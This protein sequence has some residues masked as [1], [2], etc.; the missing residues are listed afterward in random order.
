[1][2]GAGGTTRGSSAR[3]RPA[4]PSLQHGTPPSPHA[5]VTYDENGHFCGLAPLC[6]MTQLLSLRVCARHRAL[7]PHPFHSFPFPFHY[8]NYYY[9]HKHTYTRAAQQR[10]C[11]ERTLP[12]APPS[13]V[14]TSLSHT[15]AQ[16]SRPSSGSGC[17]GATK[18]SGSLTHLQGREHEQDVRE[19]EGGRG[20]MGPGGRAAAPL[21]VRAAT[22][23]AP[24]GTK[25]AP[26][27]HHQITHPHAR[28]PARTGVLART[29]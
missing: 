17:H 20:A 8:L 9:F 14:S 18:S 23:V 21:G 10:A 19:G 25:R 12:S 27:S 3:R 11:Q 1:M 15:S 13:A 7:P 28:P 29:R 24:P 4:E 5:Y 22:G 26:P 6:T 16:R 2:R